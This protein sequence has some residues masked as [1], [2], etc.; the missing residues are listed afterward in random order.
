MENK[1]KAPVSMAYPVQVSIKYPAMQ[2]RL[3]AIF[4]L[5]FF[6]LRIILLIPHLIILY[7]LQIAAFLAAWI[8]IWVI[9]FTG[10]SSPGL[11]RYIVGTLR[12][13]TRVNSYLL[14]LHD[15]YPP[16]QLND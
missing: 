8:N 7:V 4:S 16:F 2:S 14:A 5:P 1:P 10:H 12:W 6:L 9:V 3:L 13:S 11:H 15:K